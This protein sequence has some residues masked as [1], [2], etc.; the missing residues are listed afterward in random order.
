MNHLQK[1]L[2]TK[3]IISLT[4]LFVFFFYVLSLFFARYVFAA[5]LDEVAMLFERMKASTVASSNARILVLVKPTTTATEANLRIT[6]ANGFTV[7]STSTNI[8]VSTSGLPSAFQAE[9]ITAMP[10][11]GSSASSVSGQQVT[12][13]VTD[14]T[15][16]TLY[17]FY[18]TGGITN[19]STAGEYINTV[20]T[21]TS[22]ATEID[23]SRIAV[24]IVSDDQV[25]VTAQ[26]PPSFNFAL[27]GNSIA[28]GELST[29]SVSSGSITIDIDTNAENGWSAWVK[30]ANAGLN[31]ASTGDTI[32]S[33][34]TVDGTPTS[35]TAGNEHYQL[36]VDATNGTG[37][38]TPS[39]NAEY[40]GSSGS[41]GTLT[42][43]YTEIATSNGSGNNDG[44]T[45]TINAAMSALNQAADDYS[46]VLTVVGAAN[47]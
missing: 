1:K 41:G 38:G 4:I 47:F 10:G 31:S 46:D 35:Y 18:I 8:T 44:L 30:S 14:L 2:N 23:S 24:D 40:N 20:T 26:V 19:P 15:V 39:V 7:D 22:G 37:S 11:I 28:L 9:S 34:G 43:S 42:T 27:S 32:D 12:F 45:L 25:T 17:G 3:R 13:T 5:E 33:Q 16:G 36:D 29:S 6:F 21:L